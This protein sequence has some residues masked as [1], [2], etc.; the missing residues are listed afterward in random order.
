MFKRLSQTVSKFLGHSLW[1]SSGIWA[2][3]IPEGWTKSDLIRQYQ[4]VVFPVI[5]AIA[6]DA[7]KIT[8]LV[9]KDTDDDDIPLKR[10][11]FVQAM[12]RP[13][14]DQSQFQFLELHFTYLKLVGEC[15]WY[16]VKNKLTKKPQEFY[17]LRPEMMTVVVSKTNNPLGLVTGYV[18]NKPDGSKI[19]FDIDEILHF[20]MPN[21][22]NPYYG[23]GPIEAARTFIQT[24]QFSAEWTKNSLYNSGRPSGIVS[25]KGTIDDEQFMSIKKRFRDEYSGTGNAGK[26]LFLKGT[27]GID[28]QKLGMELGELALKELKDM[29]RD[30]IMMMFRVSKTMLGISEDVTLN[31]A[32][33]SRAMFKESIT[34]SEWDR[35]TD[36]LTAF[37]LPM[38]GKAD[39]LYVGYEVPDLTSGEQKI[40]EWEVGFNKWL[41]RNDIRQERG[42][43]P[44]PGGDVI[45]ESIGLV[46]ILDNKPREPL[47][48]AKDKPDEDKPDEDEPEKDKPE[49]EEDDTEEKALPLQ[50]VRSK[51]WLQKKSVFDDLMYQLQDAWMPVYQEALVIEFTKQEKEI[52]AKHGKK[53]I[54]WLFNVDTAQQR[55]IGKLLPMGLQL[56]GEAAKI[57]FELIGD[58]ETEFLID[59]KVQDYI[60][61]RVTRLAIAVNDKT[62]QLL[63]ATISEG[64]KEGENLTKLRNRVKDVYTEATTVRAEVIARTES[65]AAS[66]EG[67]LEAY[68][69]SP[70]VNGK[71]WSASSGACEFC[72]EFNGKIVELDDNFADQGT[73]LQGKGDSKYVLGYEDIGHPPLHPNCRCA[74]IPVIID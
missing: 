74:L 36:H 6:E 5:S 16:V 17:I 44:I 49:D 58:D 71:E 37:L 20:K 29:T 3:A 34:L 72:S 73:T 50:I 54:D 51:K 25:I 48:P 52:L 13:N 65:I 7:A 38:Y 28:Y 66:N 69:Q 43:D 59:Q 39:N 47:P 24:E 31:N 14:P 12:K 40:R 64:L 53:S 46:P 23:M 22:S 60:H 26:T 11:E 9:Y 55:L 45:R 42:L 4:R 62:I 19:P 30:D 18:L 32:R 35:L 33:E 67:T 27:D 10:H 8:F 21:P 2:W 1:S 63:E 56:M 41:T 57:A 70:M 15:Y 68:K 61:D